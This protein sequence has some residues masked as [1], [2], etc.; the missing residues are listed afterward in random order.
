[1][2]S[3]RAGIAGALS[4]ADRR[5]RTGGR[6]VEGFAPSLL[7]AIGGASLSL[8]WLKVGALMGVREVCSAAYLTGFIVA[9]AVL[10]GILG[11]L[12]Q[13][14]WGAAGGP[15]LRAL[16]GDRPDAYELRLVWGAAALPQVFP[17]F[18]LLPLDLLIVGRDSFTTTRLVDPVSTAWAAF[19]IALAA[20]AAVWSLFLLVRGVQAAGSLPRWRAVA[21]AS[22]ALLCL[23]AVVGAFA[24]ATFLLPQGA[25]CPT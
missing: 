20:S 25:G 1:L 2:L 5:R 24:A 19:S 22:T 9:A 18:V 10:G 11:L 16:G 14:L 13:S 8:L 3:P 17:L 4:H 6:P 7:A 15:M 21:G 23:A 12:A